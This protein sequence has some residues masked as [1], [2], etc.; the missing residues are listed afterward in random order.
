MTTWFITGTS[1]GFGRIMTE[2]LLARG[3]SVAAT[4]RNPRLLDGLRASAGDRLWVSELDV[5]DPVAVE[6]VVGAAFEHFG[7][8]DVLVS[9]A[10]YGTFGAAEELSR[11]QIRRSIDTNLLGS[12]DVIRAFIPLLRSQGHGRILQV[13]SAGGQAAVPGFAAYH[14]AKWGVEGFCESV[15]PE[16]AALGIGM[17]IVQPGAA[18]TQ[19]TPSR[20][21]G[22]TLD[23]Y[24]LGPVG[25]VRRAIAGGAIT[26]PNDPA[27]IA[28]AMIACA[29]TEPAP[30]R[31]PLGADAEA[32]LRGAYQQRLAGLDEQRD[33]ARSVALDDAAV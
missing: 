2:R 31:L 4:L 10:G 7:V 15:T 11:E 18:P 5:T 33:A 32:A 6:H 20:D 1:T 9:N 17:T 14:A 3:D 13:S 23:V 22:S 8:I 26:H 21:D 30:L 12:I 25:E 29:Q 28:D 16:L 19:F 27:K 24:D